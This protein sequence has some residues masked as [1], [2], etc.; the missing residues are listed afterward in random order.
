MNEGGIKVTAIAMK[1]LKQLAPRHDEIGLSA[2][3]S[4]LIDSE[5]R[6]QKEL[7]RSTYE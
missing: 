2:Y 1:Q 3:L 4:Q 6:K 5:H 7:S